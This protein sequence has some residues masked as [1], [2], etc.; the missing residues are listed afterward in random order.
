MISVS[1]QLNLGNAFRKFGRL[2]ECRLLQARG[3]IEDV[4]TRTH[5]LFVT[6]LRM[7]P[8]RALGKW[9]T[10]EGLTDVDQD[11]RRS[12]V[13]AMQYIWQKDPFEEPKSAIL[14][15]NIKGPK[16][17]LSAS[18]F[19]GTVLCQGQ[20]TDKEVKALVFQNFQWEVTPAP[21]NAEDLA[22][23]FIKGGYLLPVEV[24]QSSIECVDPEA[25]ARPS[26]TSP[27]AAGDSCRGIGLDFGWARVGPS[28]RRAKAE[29]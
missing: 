25:E 23:S 22:H 3:D 15:R 5:R 10:H 26:G 18:G 8:G 9:K 24:R 28:L 20:P 7:K 13:E 29:P 17:L 21:C 12:Q 16:D 11:M 4:L 2:Q 1:F 27:C 6:S 14:W 19:S